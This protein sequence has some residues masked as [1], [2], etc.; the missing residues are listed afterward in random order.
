MKQNA[1]FHLPG[2]FE[3]YELYRLFLPLFREH[4]EYFYE[5]WEIGSIVRRPTPAG[6]AGSAAGI[7]HLS[8]ADPQQFAASGR[9]ACRPQMQR[10][11]CDA[12]RGRCAEWRDRPLISSAGLPENAAPKALFRFFHDE[13][14]DRVRPAGS[15]I[16]PAGIP[17]CRAG[18]PAESGVC[19]A[20]GTFAGTEG[21]GGV[22]LQRVL[23][24]GLH[25]P[26]TLL[27]DRQSQ[28]ISASPARSTAA[29][30][31]MQRK[32]IAFPRRWKTR[33]S[34]GCRILRK[35]ICRWGFPISRSRGGVLAARWCWNFCSI[36]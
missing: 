17:V 2:L 9:A 5:G 1:V 25:E 22:S 32:G 27:R 26:E 4:R 34:S 3:F 35:R 10:P 11:L 13:S 19:K 23:L 31:R 36:I 8:P 16:E 29:P 7:R 14:A 30:P 24:D 18:F 15:R 20:G 28:K 12:G 21:Q 33:A 6:G